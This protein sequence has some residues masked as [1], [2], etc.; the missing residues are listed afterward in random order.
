[1]SIRS[2][3]TLIAVADHG[4]FVAA[5]R[6]V[7]LT[8]SAVSMQL[9]GLED[10]LRAEL[11]D[12]ARRPPTLNDRGQALVRRARDIVLL[13]ERLGETVEDDGMA[14]LLDLGAVP[15][16]LSGVVPRALAGLQQVHPRIAVNMVNGMSGELVDRVKRGELDAAIVS[17]S[18]R[19]PSGLAWH[20]VATEWIV[21][22]A[23]P[24]SVEKTDRD[25]LAAW[26]YI[27]FNRRAWVANPIQQSLRRRKIRPR[28][29][30]ELDSLESILL[31]VYYGLGV[32]VIPQRCVEGPHPL[33]IRY[34]PFGDPPLARR[35][36][37]LER[38]GNPKAKLTAA[39]HVAFKNLAIKDGPNAPPAL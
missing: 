6:A 2:L 26:P 20:P 7:G 36:G 9:R 32:S 5:A 21:V 35:I 8:Q 31:M 13:Y 39:L 12:R 37:L 33:P 14:G 15:T 28:Q 18:D 24:Q 17:E 23:P 38:A 10:E 19:L 3:R 11:F 30:M 25:L 22:A 1:M 29:A 27:R 34:I 16:T 4:S